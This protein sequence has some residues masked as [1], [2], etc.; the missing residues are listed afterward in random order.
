MNSPLHPRNIEGESKEKNLT[1]SV[2]NVTKQS[3]GERI[4]KG[5]EVETEHYATKGHYVPP[6]LKSGLEK[7][8]NDWDAALFEAT[9]AMPVNEFDVRLS[10]VQDSLDE[11]TRLLGAQAEINKQV[12]LLVMAMYGDGVHKGMRERMQSLEDSRSWYD[13]IFGTFMVATITAIVGGF[14]AWWYKVK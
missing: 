6:T 1:E 4:F 7:V 11:I 12:A 10:R 3:T 8:C 9:Y 5:R 2:P 13:K 14:F